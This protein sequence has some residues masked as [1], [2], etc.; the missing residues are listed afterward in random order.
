MKPIP[1][2]EDSCFNILSSFSSASSENGSLFT[3]IDRKFFFWIA[4]EFVTDNA[5]NVRP[6]KSPSKEIPYFACFCFLNAS[7]NEFSTAS[8]PEFVKKAA[9]KPL[10][11]IEVS[12]SS[13]S[14]CSWIE[15]SCP[16]YFIGNF[17][18]FFIISFSSG[19]L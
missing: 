16:A 6:W 10:G 15:K 8:A 4:F 3:G 13:K 11:V 7:F 9:F 14:R 18:Y 12:S 17:L 2:A 19:W 1:L 5:P